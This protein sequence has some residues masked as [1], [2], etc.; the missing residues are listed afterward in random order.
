MCLSAISR[1][2][3]R[4]LTSATPR[5]PRVVTVSSEHGPSI[6]DMIWNIT[7]SR[8][9]DRLKAIGRRLAL[10]DW[11]LSFSKKIIVVLAGTTTAAG[12]CVPL[13][14]HLRLRSGPLLPLT[15][16]TNPKP[17]RNRT[18]SRPFGS[19]ES[20]PLVTIS[21]RIICLICI[22]FDRLERFQSGIQKKKRIEP[23]G[24]W[25]PWAR[26]VFGSLY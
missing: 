11:E 25:F 13:S 10:A 23:E 26:G 1:W 20:W 22:S 15:T 19:L 4:A 2:R 14:S 5:R 3:L 12:R 7:R 16:S 21:N 18:G 9:L 24:V 6:Y 8:V 17:F